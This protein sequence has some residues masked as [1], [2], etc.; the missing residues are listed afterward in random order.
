MSLTTWLLLAAAFAV[1]L[2]VR[3]LRKQAAPMP[4]QPPAPERPH[5]VATP[6]PATAPTLPKPRRPRPPP[7]TAADDAARDAWESGSI[8]VMQAALALKPG[9]VQRHFLLQELVQQTYRRRKEPAMAALC[10]STAE[11]Y[12][13]EFP[14]LYP[15]LVEDWR[16]APVVISVFQQLATLLTEQGDYARAIQVCELALAKGLYDGTVSGFE[17]R[18]ARIKKASAKVA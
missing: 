5:L 9:A 10:R 16:G 17:G 2:A 12:L 7:P 13:A 8:H 18:I 11:T 3:W 6:Q 4:A 14:A 15:A 1:L